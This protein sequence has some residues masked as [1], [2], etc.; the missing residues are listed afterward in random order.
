MHPRIFRQLRVERCHEDPPVANEHRLALVLGEHLDVLTGHPHP[1][2]PDKD[3]AE[4][5]LVPCELEVGL[6][7]GHLAAVG[8]PVDLH[9]GEA[10]VVA[11]EDDHAGAGTK[12]RSLERPI[13]SSSPYSLISRMNVVDSPPGTTNPSSPASSSGFRISTGSAPSRRSIASCSRKFPWTAS[14]PIRI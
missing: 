6:E 10:E 3:S 5:P 4:R 2:R 9:V 14:T 1:R 12:D 8:I 7:G 11:I 13:A